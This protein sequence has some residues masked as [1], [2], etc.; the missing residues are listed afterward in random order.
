M[1]LPKKEIVVHF[2]PNSVTMVTVTMDNFN[3]YL[4]YLPLTV[5]TLWLRYVFQVDNVYIMI[6]IYI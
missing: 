4:G 1:G 5:F 3:K 6:V 2:L